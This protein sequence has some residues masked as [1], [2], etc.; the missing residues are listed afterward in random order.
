[1]DDRI[2]K[3]L[4]ESWLPKAVSSQISIRHLLTHTSGL[5]SYFNPTYWNSS[6]ELF[7]KLDDYKALIKDDRPAFE[8][9]ARFQYS[10]TGM[11][12]LGVIIER[13]TGTDYFEHIRTT[14]YRPAGMT[15][16]DCYELDT[17]V[18]NLAVGY[19]LDPT[20]PS[21]WRNNIFKHVLKGGPAGGGY[22]T[23]RDLHKFALA[24]LTGK[25]VSKDSLNLMWTNQTGAD[26]GF[27]FAVAESPGGKIVGHSG[28]FPGIHSNLDIF[29]DSGYIAAVMSNADPGAMPLV[30]LTRTAIRAEGR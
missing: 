20:S 30:D 10:N 19:L 27:G 14:I 2:D 13:V 24:L 7:R 21:G 29:V 9:G 1:L 22:S 12:L 5:G 25:L 18:E 8:P 4:D 17:P 11:F 16:S 26:Y 6:R 23:V 15:D 28:G 3:Y